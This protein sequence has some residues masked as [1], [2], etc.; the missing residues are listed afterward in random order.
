MAH[1]EHLPIYKKAYDLALH[2]ETVVRGFPRDHK[3]TLGVDLRNKS[4]L[5]LEAIITAN[6]AAEGRV[7]VLLRLR[8]ELETLKTL[9]RLC[10]D[11]QAFK[12]AK[13][14]FHVAEMVVDIARQNE[15]WLRVSRGAASQSKV[16]RTGE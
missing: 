6:G 5:A 15:G 8:T 14:Y 9:V 13:A 7:E 1:Y 3:Y 4:R 12:S 11:S 10:H 2:M 16:V